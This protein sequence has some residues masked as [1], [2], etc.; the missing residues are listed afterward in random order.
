MYMIHT[1]SNNV[2]KKSIEHGVNERY[3]ETDGCMLSD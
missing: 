2:E 1:I 3:I